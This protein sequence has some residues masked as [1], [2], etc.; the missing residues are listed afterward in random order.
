MQLME[1]LELYDIFPRIRKAFDSSSWE[2][3]CLTLRDAN[4][5]HFQKSALIDRT[6]TCIT[7]QNPIPFS[8]V[9]RVGSPL[10]WCQ[11]RANRAMK[12]CASESDRFHLDRGVII[13]I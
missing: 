9:L 8:V 10:E 12:T 11:A 1:H 4:N 5:P 7:F 3:I 6:G 13:Y 2:P